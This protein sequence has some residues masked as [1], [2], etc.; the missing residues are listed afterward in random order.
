MVKASG[1]NDREIDREVRMGNPSLTLFD[2]V[3]PEIII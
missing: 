1:N 2:S 3:D